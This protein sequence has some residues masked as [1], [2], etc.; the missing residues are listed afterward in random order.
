MIFADPRKIET[1]V[2]FLVSVVDT[3]FLF[4]FLFVV[5]LFTSVFLFL[6]VY[7]F[8][9]S[10]LVPSLPLKKARGGIAADRGSGL[11][12]PIFYHPSPWMS[13]PPPLAINQ[14][15]T[16]VKSPRD[17]PPPWKMPPHFDMPPP[18]PARLV[19][20][21][22]TAAKYLAL[23]GQIS[24]FIFSRHHTREI[25]VFYFFDIWVTALCS[26]CWQNHDF[27]EHKAPGVVNRLNCFAE[28]FLSVLRKHNAK[29]ESTKKKTEIDTDLRFDFFVASHVLEENCDLMWRGKGGLQVAEKLE[30]VQP[31]KETTTGV[32]TAG[33]CSSFTGEQEA[34][35]RGTFASAFVWK[36]LCFLST[37]PVC[38]GK[39]ILSDVG[40]S[41]FWIARGILDLFRVC[42]LSEA[43]TAS[44]RQRSNCLDGLVGEGET[45][46]TMRPAL[47]VGSAAD[48]SIFF[49]HFSLF[50]APDVGMVGHFLN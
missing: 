39:L 33:S 11:T 43:Q 46:K 12:R 2:Y 49:V 26:F 44:K 13:P 19:W 29:L 30:T 37:P 38:L 8:R 5:I 14:V 7:F 45:L 21:W 47:E 10:D 36:H 3:V 4:L 22:P 35:D 20:P 27:E 48:F 15:R 9:R 32:L 23:W 6:S 34:P 18:P 25:T 1:F 42:V 16:K 28:I 40:K 31:S 41:R 50:G 24:S 17:M